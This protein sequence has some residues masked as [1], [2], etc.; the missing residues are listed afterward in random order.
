M[1]PVLNRWVRGYLAHFPVTE[2]KKALLRLTRRLIT[3]A[4]AQQTTRTRHGFSLQLNLDNPEHQRIYFYGEHDERYETALLKAIVRPGMTCWDIGANIGYYSCLLALAVG[5]AGRVIAFE[6]ARETRARLA[7][8]VAL[9]NLGNVEVVPCAVGAAEGV[10]RIHY[11]EAGLFEGTASLHELQ[12]QA[13]SEEVPLASVDS[14]V[15]RFGAPDFLK[16]DVEGAQLDVWRGGRAFFSSRHPLVMAE[17]RDS[18]DPGVLA[19]IESIVRGYGY[20]IFSIRKGRRVTEA[21][22]L[23]PGG[24]RNYMLAKSG[25]GEER[26]LLSLAA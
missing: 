22:R 14:L 25:T 12:G 3:P 15:E 17:L 23:A 16:I 18:T 10:A 9:N 13:E 4:E 6:P 11:R 2:G 1:R 24:P 5:S 8:N 20:R 21:P 19:A 26:L 7:H